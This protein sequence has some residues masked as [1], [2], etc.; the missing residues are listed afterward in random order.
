MF[1]FI[2]ELSLFVVFRRA[3]YR[4]RT[5]G[6]VEYRSLNSSVDTS[7][8]GKLIHSGVEHFLLI[9]ML[10]F[11]K[12]TVDHGKFATKFHTERLPRQV[13][14]H[15]SCR[16]P[17]AVRSIF[18]DRKTALKLTPVSLNFKIVSSYDALN[19]RKLFKTLET[20]L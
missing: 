4:R 1:L 13:L 20:F 10:Q 11:D 2:S 3:A 8:P 18:H 5:D 16:R 6:T 15:R 9:P 7:E 12:G 19:C 14:S 17:S